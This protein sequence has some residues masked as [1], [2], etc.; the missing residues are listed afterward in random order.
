MSEQNSNADGAAGLAV[1]VDRGDAGGAVVIVQG[2]IDLETSPEL[3]AVLAGL[4][5]PGDVDLDLGSVTYIDS[6]GLRAL[7][8]AR[9][10]AIEAGG[11]LRV[12]AM[13]SIVAR[14]IEITGCNELL[15]R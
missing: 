12:S 5:P 15:E 14:L 10:A 1:T 11:T 2:E 7:L 4:E 6:T 13:S 9:D 3:S 8:S